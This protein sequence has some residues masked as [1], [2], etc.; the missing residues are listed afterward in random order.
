MNFKLFTIFIFFINVVSSASGQDIAFLKFDYLDDRHQSKVRF[1]A[2]SFSI[3]GKIYHPDHKV[4]QIVINA[5]GFDEI[6]YS[7]HGKFIDKTFLTRFKKD[8]IYI[9]QYNTCT[10]SY[11]LFAKNNPGRGEVKFVNKSQTPIVGEIGYLIHEKVEVNSESTFQDALE[12]AMCYYKVCALKIYQASFD[13]EKEYT[14]EALEQ[15]LLGEM[16]FHFLHKEKIIV[17]YIEEGK[18]SLRLV[19]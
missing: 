3:N 9:I 17:E 1:E 18:L 2:L 15:L 13:Y 7:E 19:E 8:E 4:H 6:I 12:S 10:N 16:Y 11:V 5:K 14:L